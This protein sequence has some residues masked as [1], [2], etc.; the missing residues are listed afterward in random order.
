M[1]H[2][3]F[4]S[5]N[6]IARLIRDRQ[7]SSGEVVQAYLNQI[8]TYNP[9]LNA[10]VTLD[11]E[12]AL[13][14]AQK[15]DNALVQGQV[16]GPLHGVPFTIKDVFATAGMRT[17]SGSKRLANYIP[18]EDATVV[19]RIRHAGA[20]LL[21]KTNTPEFATDVKT[22]NLLFGCTNNPWDLDRTPGGSSGGSAVAIAAGFS[23]L[24]IGSDLG[25]SI[26][27]P[28]S[29]CGIFGLKTTDMLVAH[30][31]HIPPPPGITSWGL[32]RFLVSI[33]PLARSIE[34][35]RL[36]LELIAGYDGLQP[37]IPPVHLNLPVKAG[38]KRLR[39]AWMDD[40]GVPL[41]SE[42]KSV[43]Q[44]L[45]IRL[46][47]SGCQVEKCSPPGVDFRNALRADAELEQT[48]LQS[49]AVLP[50]LLFKTISP[51]LY[52]RDPMA[53]GYFLGYGANLSSFTDAMIARDMLIGKLEGFLDEWDTWMVPA[54]ATPAFL[55]TEL[56]SPIGRLRLSIDINGKPVPYYLATLG[57]TN[58]FNLTGSSAV[59]I[60][61]GKTHNGRPVGVQLVGKR[62][63]D[64]ELLSIAEQ[65]SRISGAFQAPE[66]FLPL[67]NGN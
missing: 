63:H 65:I 10:V 36:A 58:L 11:G 57:Y 28:A 32:M 24:E 49:K 60:P 42:V 48:A 35:L 26:R 8:E 55:H 20:I 30:T 38:G 27:R 4:K 46:E 59:V 16:W 41:D 29:Y 1:N 39:I 40:L 22:D 56:S 53:S 54:C 44:S 47:Q 31:G 18:K 64:M 23:A 12:G 51:L 3:I 7:V 37:E 45:A 43:I 62:W 50:R 34:D 6:E 14:Q 61:A 9:K 2:I 25:G 21:G 19:S 13:E 66:K 17:T 15:A 5:A 33:G 52:K 67:G